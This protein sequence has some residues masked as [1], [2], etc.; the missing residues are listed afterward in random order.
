M[1]HQTTVVE[2]AITHPATGGHSTVTVTAYGPDGVPVRAI[3][4]A[5]H[6]DLDVIFAAAGRAAQ[7]AWDLTP[8]TFREV[9][10]VTLPGGATRE[11]WIFD[12]TLAPAGTPVTP[13]R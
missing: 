11:I 6:A 8:A 9:T 1:T 12:C 5:H 2:L 3:E 7:T 10:I 4:I 13:T